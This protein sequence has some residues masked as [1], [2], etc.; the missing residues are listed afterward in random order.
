MLWTVLGAA[1]LRMGFLDEL[2]GGSIHLFLLS[3][4][5]QPID[6]I[7]DQRIATPMVKN[8]VL[9]LSRLVRAL[10][11]RSPSEEI[12]LGFLRMAF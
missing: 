7:E 9:E 2:N 4:P 3:V 6:P 11:L 8:V 5:K 12:S 1:K 10:V